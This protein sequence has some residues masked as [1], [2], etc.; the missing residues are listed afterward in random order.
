M[1]FD[2]K[3]FTLYRFNFKLNKTEETIWY[4]TLN[5]G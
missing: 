4:S 3:V 1:Y 2:I 5:I